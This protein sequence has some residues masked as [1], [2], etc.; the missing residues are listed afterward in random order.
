M[1]YFFGEATFEVFVSN[2]NL[3]L[4]CWLARIGD[5]VFDEI[6]KKHLASVRPLYDS[7]CKLDDIS[8]IWSQKD[9]YSSF[10]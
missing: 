8:C 5:S 3:F 6:S 9:A 2:K 7:L 10:V 1:A 4:Y